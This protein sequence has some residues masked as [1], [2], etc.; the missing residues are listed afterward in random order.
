MANKP[1]KENSPEMFHQIAPTYDFMNR[2]MTLGLDKKWRKKLIHYLPLKADKLLDAATGTGD[3]ILLLLQQGYKVKKIVGIDL[4]EGMLDIAKKKLKKA[5]IR[6][7]IEFKKE[8]L[9][10][11][12]FAD[13]SFDAITLSFGIRNIPDLTKAL[14]ELYRILKPGGKCVILESS[15]FKNP[16]LALMQRF[17]MSQLVPILGTVIAKNSSAYRYLNDT[18]QDFPMPD[19]FVSLLASVGFK[20]CCYYPLSG[21]VVCIYVAAK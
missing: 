8:N 13:N 10:Q 11:T 18:T 16:L 9:L 5:G 12:S 21:G 1:S 19:A 7:R 3:Q 14:K 15:K 6:K 17:Y 2:L 4:A 20:D